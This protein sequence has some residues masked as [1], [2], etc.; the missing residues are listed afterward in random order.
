M[1]ED[2]KRLIAKK[3]RICDLLNGQYIKKSGWEPSYITTSQGNISRVN[4]MAFLV[5]QNKDE[6]I[7]MVDDGTGNISVRFFT[8]LTSDE[9]NVGEL[10]LIIGRPRGWNNEFYIVPEIVKKIENPKWLQVRKLELDIDST[11]RDEKPAPIKKE[12][13]KEE[14]KIKSEQKQKKEEETPETKPS[15]NPYEVVLNL[16]TELDN[17]DG[18]DIDEVISKTTFKNTEDIINNLIQ[19]GEIFQLRPGMVKIL[20]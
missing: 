12:K 18:A 6:N 11:S 17:G 10:L 1:S 20:E 5:G 9:I 3:V 8:K 7:F 16:I 2:K 14:S 4:L 13:T 15:E 19:D